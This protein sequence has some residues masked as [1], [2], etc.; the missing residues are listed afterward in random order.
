MSDPK[1]NTIPN[2]L[3]SYD[4]EAIKLIDHC[5]YILPIIRKRL[6]DGIEM[7]DVGVKA[8][9]FDEPISIS[10]H[11]VDP[12]GEIAVDPRRQKRRGN[13]KKTREAVKRVHKAM[14]GALDSATQASL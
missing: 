9:S 14:M 4:K 1:N 2:S 10:G 6:L 12:V 5:L 3:S 8:Q 13:I 7:M 11:L